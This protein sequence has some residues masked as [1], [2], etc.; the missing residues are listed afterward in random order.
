MSITLVQSKPAQ[1]TG[2]GSGNV[3]FTSNVTAGNLLVFCASAWVGGTQPTISAGTDSQGN[4]WY[5][6]DQGANTSAGEKQNGGITYCIAGSSGALTYYPTITGTLYAEFTLN[7]FS[8]TDGWPAAPLDVHSP[9]SGSSTT[10]TSGATGAKSGNGGVVVGVFC[11][12]ISASAGIDLP[13]GFTNI[14]LQQSNSATINASHDYKTITSGDTASENVSWGT[15]SS[16]GPWAASVAFFKDNSTSGPIDTPITVDTN[17]SFAFSPQSI[18]LTLSQYAL[19][20]DANTA[21]VFS[22]QDIILVGNNNYTLP[23]DAS[24][25]VTFTAGSVLFTIT[26]IE[27]ADTTLVFS[28]QD[29]ILTAGVAFT[30]AVTEATPA[31]TLSSV[32]LTWV[33]NVALVV[34]TASMAITGQA[35]G[36]SEGFGT[37]SLGVDSVNL[38]ISSQSVNLLRSLPSGSGDVSPRT[39]RY[40]LKYGHHYRR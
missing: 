33:D 36:F 20:V 12:D 2:S 1:R 17:T 24:T 26:T 15:L 28:G 37:A 23:V 3:V 5:V 16:S 21:F 39:L 6:A 35:V 11:G 40:R 4:T 27:G 18:T 10:P 34:A 22:P 29:I 19:T 7:E 38:T 8:S 13:T 32:T 14:L 30:L 25:N 31:F 9:N